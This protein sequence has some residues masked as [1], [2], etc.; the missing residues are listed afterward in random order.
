MR[1]YDDQRNEIKR[2]MSFNRWLD[3]LVSLHATF[4]PFYYD[5][6][7]YSVRAEGPVLNVDMSYIASLTEEFL[8]LDAC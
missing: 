3:S 7:P 8:A 5:Q 2:F 1:P 6:T 4:L